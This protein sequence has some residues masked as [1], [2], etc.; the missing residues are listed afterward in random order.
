[1]RGGLRAGLE[2]EKVGIALGD[3]ERFAADISF[4]LV[5]GDT[6]ENSGSDKWKE[7]YSIDW[8]C[9]EHVACYALSA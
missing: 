7:T 3:E 4:W 9:C 6:G 1:V 5:D 8:V 2:P